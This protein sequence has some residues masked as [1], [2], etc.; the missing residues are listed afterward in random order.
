MNPN[1]ESICRQDRGGSS[2]AAGGPIVGVHSGRCVDVPGWSG[3]NGTQVQ[4]WD[5]HGGTAIWDCTGGVNQQ[6]RS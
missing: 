6:W 5:R 3:T 4:L 2:P 1:R